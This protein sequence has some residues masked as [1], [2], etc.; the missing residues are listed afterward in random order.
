[1]KSWSESTGRP[2]HEAP[3]FKSCREDADQALRHYEAAQKNPALALHLA[4]ADTLGVLAETAL[5]CCRTPASVNP[6][7]PRLRWPRPGNARNRPKN[8]FP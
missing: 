3:N 4:R 7:P 5:R 8:S 2:V 1:M 6:L